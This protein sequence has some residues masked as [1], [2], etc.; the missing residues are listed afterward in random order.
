MHR[1]CV[2]SAL[3]RGLEVPCAALA[4][5]IPSPA[6]GPVILIYC[7]CAVDLY[8]TIVVYRLQ[9]HKKD[10]HHEPTNERMKFCLIHG[11]SHTSVRYLQIRLDPVAFEPMGR[12]YDAA[13]NLHKRHVP[14]SYLIR[15]SGFLQISTRKSRRNLTST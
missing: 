1:A 7:T 9:V 11:M 12:A 2:L 4:A 6:R 5:R 15:F 13:Q 3:V 8:H 10:E 14:F